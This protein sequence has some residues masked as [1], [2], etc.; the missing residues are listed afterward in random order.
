MLQLEFPNISHKSEYLAM[1]AE[2]KDFEPTPTSPGRLFVWE[3]YEEFL[4]I[5]EQDV[6]NSPRWVN[7]SLFF[8]MEDTSLL[9][10]IQIRHHINH[11]HLSSW[12]WHIGYGL[13][14]NARGKWLAKEMLALGLIEAK[15]LWIE[16]VMIG[17]ND[18]NPA[19]WK[20]IESC[21]GIF[22]KFTLHEWKKSRIYW[23]K[24]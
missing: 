15:K 24:L 17:A 2:W 3:S 22:E 5:I 19:S 12:G 11:P 6:T 18:D 14:P 21:G 4:Q 16:K 9:G 1:I 13:R 10:A 7:S 20:T 23:I 8:F